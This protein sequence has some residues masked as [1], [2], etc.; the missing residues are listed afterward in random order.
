VTDQPDAIWVISDVTPGGTYV[1][2]VQAGPDH[3]ATLTRDDALAYAVTVFEA[4]T[5]AEYDAG[6]VA[7][8]TATGMSIVL[9]GS[10]VTDLRADRPPLVDAGH[11]LTYEPIVTAIKREPALLVCRDG[12]RIAQWTPADAR[13]H[14]GNVLSV[15][16][17]VDL[18]AAYRRLLVG[19]IGLDDERARA[20]VGQLGQYLAT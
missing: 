7:Q 1:V 15:L 13:S 9:A 14:A 6:V 17:A 19:A 20:L 3:A 11:P 4:A 5:R 12:E 8:L 10:V 2:T 18:D 16:A